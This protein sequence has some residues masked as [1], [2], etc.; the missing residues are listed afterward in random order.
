MVFRINYIFS[1]GN[2]MHRSFQKPRLL[3][4]SD[5]SR[6]WQN[7]EMTT[8]TTLSYQPRLLPGPE[9]AAYLGIS[10][11]TLRTLPIAR[12][13]LGS[14]KLYDRIDLDA[15]AS[16]LPTEDAGENTCDM[17]FD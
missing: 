15:Y 12:R 14:W 3:G 6:S 16:S 9:A 1:S 5:A 7:Q 8:R 4:R 13:K 17:V 10:L 2:T 11:S